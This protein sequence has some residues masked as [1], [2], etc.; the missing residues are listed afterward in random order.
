MPLTL[1]IIGESVKKNFN[2][3]IHCCSIILF[4]FLSGCTVKNKTITIPYKTTPRYTLSPKPERFLLLNTY[5][6]DSTKFRKNKKELFNKFIDSIL[7]TCKEEIIKRESIPCEVLPGLTNISTSIDDT[8]YLMIREH[9][10]T[11]AIVITSFDVDFTKTEVMV[12]KSANGS[13]SRNASYD[14]VSDIHFLLYS[15]HS[16]FKESQMTKSTYYSSRL[17][18]SGLLAAGP[19][20]VVQKRDAWKITRSNLDDYLNLFFKSN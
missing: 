9:Q 19:N 6:I 17:V 10:A 12:E 3:L 13:K 5:N 8:V 14:I 16:V 11:H 1:N 18:I 4:F 20:V 15:G 7:V 2:T